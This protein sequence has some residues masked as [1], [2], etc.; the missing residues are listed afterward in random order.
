MT[1]HRRG[2]G[3]SLM[4]YKGQHP[5][6][7]LQWG[8]FLLIPL[9]LLWISHT[10]RSTQISYRIQKLEEELEKEKNKRVELEIAR[11]RLLSLETVEAAA[12]RKLGLVVP[13]EENIVAWTLFHP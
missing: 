8:V 1:E 13:Q 6:R 4:C 11:D 9:S 3:G 2:N 5:S 10:V 7:K 12:K